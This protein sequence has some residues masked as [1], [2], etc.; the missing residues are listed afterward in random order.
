MVSS[1]P[2][3]FKGE[4]VVSCRPQGDGE[5]VTASE[6]EDVTSLQALRAV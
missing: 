3:Y 4:L 6:R 1:S 5:A 2:C